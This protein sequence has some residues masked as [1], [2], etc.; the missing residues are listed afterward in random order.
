MS[1]SLNVFRRPAGTPKVTAVCDGK[2]FGIVL[3]QK[4]GL[5]VLEIWGSQYLTYRKLNFSE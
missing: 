5:S 1:L 4:R 3:V 2:E